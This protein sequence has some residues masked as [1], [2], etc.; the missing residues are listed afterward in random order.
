VF[1]T[2][3]FWLGLCVLRRTYRQ[4]YETLFHVVILS[5]YLHQ[6]DLEDAK[7]LAEK[8]AKE[9]AQELAEAEQ[10]GV[11]GGERPKTPS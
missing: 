3:A 6:K 9:E 4:H 11:W 8:K 2:Y 10:D 5:K 1:T 7:L